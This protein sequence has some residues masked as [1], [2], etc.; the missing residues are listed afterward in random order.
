VLKEFRLNEDGEV[1]EE[2]TAESHRPEHQTGDTVECSC[3]KE[4]NGVNAQS[5]AVEHLRKASAIDEVEP[6]DLKNIDEY[7][8]E[9][10]SAGYQAQYENV[11]SSSSGGFL[12]ILSVEGSEH[13]VFLGDALGHMVKEVKNP[14]HEVTD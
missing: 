6:G 5:E 1:E 12:S 10:R 2:I 4:W 8:E 13:S 11:W 3:G 9:L 14:L 7:T